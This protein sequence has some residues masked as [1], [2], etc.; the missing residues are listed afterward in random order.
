MKI[1]EN[2][3]AWLL[4]AFLPSRDPACGGIR[5]DEPGRQYGRVRR[6]HCRPDLHQCVGNRDPSC[7]PGRALLVESNGTGTSN[8]FVGDVGGTPLYSDKLRLDPFPAQ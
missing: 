6:E 8:Q 2:K 3:Q 5:A 4:C 7:R 1:S